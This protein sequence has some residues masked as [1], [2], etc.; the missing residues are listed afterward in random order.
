M[1]GSTPMGSDFGWSVN[2]PL[3][4]EPILVGI[5]S[6]VHWGYGVWWILF[7]MSFYLLQD[8]HLCLRFVFFFA[9]KCLGQHQ[10]DPIFVGR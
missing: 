9:G 2:P 7:R 1:L 5:E 8:R 10:W 4:L 3:I 6:D